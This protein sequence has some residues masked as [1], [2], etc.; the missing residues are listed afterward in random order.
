MEPRGL[1]KGR[2]VD[3]RGDR[4]ADA[5]TL[6]VWP[7]YHWGSGG[8]TRPLS[9]S[10]DVDQD[11]GCYADA[12]SFSSPVVRHGHSNLYVRLRTN[13]NKVGACDGAH[14][15]LATDGSGPLP[16]PSV[17]FSVTY[18]PITAGGAR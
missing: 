3:G 8:H 15:F 11:L 16:G 12:M 10:D 14:P 9:C 13:I 5:R 1:C 17:A 2:S 18:G 7:S 6:G 4:D